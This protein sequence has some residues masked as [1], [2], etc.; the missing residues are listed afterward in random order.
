[1][2]PTGSSHVVT[3][4]IEA[5][6]QVSVIVQVAGVT[7]GGTGQTT[8]SASA[9]IYCNGALPGLTPQA[10]CPPDVATQSTL[11]LIL[12]TVTLL[13]RQ[14]APFGYIAGASHAGLSGNGV[15]TVAGII[16]I[17]VDLT[18]LPGRLGDTLGDPVTLWDAGWINLGTAD[19]FGP[20][21]FIASDPFLVFPVS[22]AVTQVGYSIPADVACT[23]T[24]LVR[25]A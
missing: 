2:Y 4:P 17:K 1:V 16:G 24:E 12:K 5:P 9:D 25:E 18:T 19:G 22:G 15:L 6:S 20:R 23:I 7:G 10:C 21:Q 14:I 3:I 13:Q 11:D 8:V